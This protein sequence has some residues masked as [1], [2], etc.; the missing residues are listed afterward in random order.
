[1]DKP[2][3]IVPQKAV[4]IQAGKFLVLKR[5]LHAAHHAGDWDFPGGK[6]EYGEGPGQGLEREVLEET[7]LKVKA[8]RPVF[9]FAE[10]NK[11]ENDVFIV[12]ECKKVSG[13][14]KL[15][16]E[17]TEWKWASKD[18]A[19]GMGKIEPFLRAYLE[20]LK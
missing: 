7:G 14:V 1:M 3:F 5:S 10:A 4:I 12:W 6:L 19:L 2:L 8:V 9:V 11:D 20:S 18:E 16:H 13:E 15:S 17:H